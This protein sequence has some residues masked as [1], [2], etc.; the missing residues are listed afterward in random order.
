LYGGFVKDVKRKSF[1]LADY[2][3]DVPEDF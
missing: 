1:F 2:V 3:K